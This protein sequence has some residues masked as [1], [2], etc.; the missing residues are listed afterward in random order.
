MHE[1]HIEPR[2]YERHEARRG[3]RHAYESLDPHR[4]ALVVVDMV[5]FF[6]TENPYA[7]G[8]VPNI[9]ALA[10]ALRTAG[11]TAAWVVPAVAAPTPAMVEFF[12]DT[13]AATYAASG[14]PGAPRDR[15]SNEFDIGE[16][17]LV[18]EKTS[19]GAFFPGRCELPE[20]LQQRGVDTV[21]VTGT[22]A[23]VCCESTARDASTQ[24]FG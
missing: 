14:G 19:A 7:R 21:L 10:A 15:V 20:L 23:N 9:R 17:D 16:G 8:I 22:V 12:G 18:V 1:W 2:E 13:V 4:T 5:P 6:L 3:R 11:G 24:G